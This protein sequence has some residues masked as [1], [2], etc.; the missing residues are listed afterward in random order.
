MKFSPNQNWDKADFW[1]PIW[2]CHSSALPLEVCWYCN[3]QSINLYY[4]QWPLSKGHNLSSYSVFCIGPLQF[5]KCWVDV[6]GFEPQHIWTHQYV[7]HHLEGAAVQWLKSDQGHCC[8]MA[9]R[10]TYPITA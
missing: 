10:S 8:P 4:G 1:T 7:D 9:K 5:S 3:F 2:V 6:L